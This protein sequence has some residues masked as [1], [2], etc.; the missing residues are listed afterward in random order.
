VREKNW[1]WLNKGQSLFAL[2][3]PACL[4]REQTIARGTK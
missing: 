2:L 4:Q 1:L 3:C